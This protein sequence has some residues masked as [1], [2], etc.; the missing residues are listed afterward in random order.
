MLLCETSYRN[1]FSSS[2]PEA[3]VNHA[4]MHVGRLFIT[5]NAWSLHVKLVYTW[6]DVR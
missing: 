2:C 1:F 3:R 6:S 4:A 5:P